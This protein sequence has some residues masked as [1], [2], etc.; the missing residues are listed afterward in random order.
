MSDDGTYKLVLNSGYVYDGFGE[1]KTSVP[2]YIKIGNKLFKSDFISLPE[3]ITATDNGGVL[4][5]ILNN[6]NSPVDIRKEQPLLTAKQSV[7]TTLE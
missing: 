6:Y 2:T 1:I 7:R 4:E 5:V 3:N